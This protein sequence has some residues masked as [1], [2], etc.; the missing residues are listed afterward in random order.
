MRS[1]CSE[2]CIPKNAVG[3]ARH[4]SSE[5]RTIKLK[6]H[7]CNSDIVRRI[8]THRHAGPKDHSPVTRRSDCNAR[9]TDIDNKLHLRR[10]RR[11]DIAGHVGGRCGERVGAACKRSRW[12][13]G[14]HARRDIGDHRTT[15][16]KRARPGDHAD[17]RARLGRSRDIGRRI[18]RGRRKRIDDG[19]G[20]RSGINGDGECRRRKRG[21]SGNVLGRGRN[22]MRLAGGESGGSDDDTRC[23]RGPRAHF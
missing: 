16:C 18:L 13:K 14:P 8:G 15:R 9:G 2:S 20:R 4:Q 7:A 11:A 23:R 22:G 19:S 1:A 17:L 21:V 3:G 10:A 12:R 6:L 5:I